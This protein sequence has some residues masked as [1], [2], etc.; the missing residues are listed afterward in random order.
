MI[1]TQIYKGLI[2]NKMYSNALLL[3]S[4]DADDVGRSGL[5]RLE[6][7]H[8]GDLLFSSL[9][10]DDRFFYNR[11]ASAD[12]AIFD[13]LYKYE[14][15]DEYYKYKEVPNISYSG[16]ELYLGFDSKLSI[17]ANARDENGNVLFNLPSLND[18]KF[19]KPVTNIIPISTTEIA[20][21]FEDQ[22]LICSKVQDE[23]FGYRYDYYPTKLTTGT[24]KGDSVINTI[25]G[26]FTIF[27]TVRGLAIMNYQ[28]FMATT[29]QALTYISDPIEER[30]DKFYAESD[31]IQLIQ[32]RNRLFLT[33]GTGHILIYELDQNRWW[34]WEVPVNISKLVT[35]QIDLR[36]IAEKLHIF[37]EHKRYEDF[38]LTPDAKPITWYVI[39]QPLHLNAPNYYKNLKQ[40]IFQLLGETDDEKKHSIVAQIQCYRKKLSTKEPEIIE[41]K[42]DNLRTFVKRFNYWKINEVQYALGSDNETVI[43]TQ[44]K[45]NGVS[46]N[47]NSVTKFDRR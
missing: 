23:T 28:A 25:E 5:H 27:P 1:Y 13:F 24:R 32:L 47:T 37:K 29:D 21:F 10:G 2:D 12:S 44:L 30:Y 46:I 33:N 35:D 41:F 18:Q 11:L 16:S 38:P 40:L 9:G 45:L 4:Y 6:S 8:N 14:F 22:I 15:M 43:P 17:S 39:S 19:I 26:T 36:L 7:V 34:F 20:V 31:S 42:I 3:P